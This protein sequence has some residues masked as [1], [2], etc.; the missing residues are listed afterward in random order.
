MKKVKRYY[1][2][3][4]EKAKLSDEEVEKLEDNIYS[5]F[6]SVYDAFIEIGRNGI[7]SVK[8]L[9]LAKKTAVTN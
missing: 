2:S 9:K 8:E 4:K 5:K 6:D 1:R 7:E 3:V